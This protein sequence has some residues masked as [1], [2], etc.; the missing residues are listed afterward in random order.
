VYHDSK[1]QISSCTR[2]NGRWQRWKKDKNNLLIYEMMVMFRRVRFYNT[3]VLGLK[4]HIDR[5]MR[6]LTTTTS[7]S[8]A[9][10]ARAISAN[11]AS[12]CAT[13]VCVCV[14]VCLHV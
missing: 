7:M 2:S 6:R 1:T 11:L 14:C 3:R 10:V 13:L 12:A 5:C 4:D 8:D 9:Q